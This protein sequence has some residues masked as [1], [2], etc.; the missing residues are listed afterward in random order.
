[1]AYDAGAIESTLTIDRDP[2]QAGLK[3]ARAEAK[4][5]EQQRF[6]AR[7]GADTRD[8][9]TA[10]K[11]LRAEGQKWDR[12]SYSAK[13]K[14][15]TRDADQGMAKLQAAARQFERTAPTIRPRADTASARAAL[16][17]LDRTRMSPKELRVTAQIETAL[18]NIDRVE[19][20][21]DALIRKRTDPKITAD[22]TDAENKVRSMERHLT[23][24]RSQTVTPQVEVQIGNSEAMLA[25]LQAHLDGLRDGRAAVDLDIGSAQAKLAMLHAQMAGITDTHATVDIDTSRASQRIA[26]LIMLIGTLGAA[27]STAGIAGA[28]GLAALGAGAMAVVPGI[29]AAALGFSGVTD[30]VKAMSDQQGKAAQTGAAAASSAKANANAQANAAAQ[31]ASAERSLANARASAAESGARAARAVEKAREEASEG[32]QRAIERERAAERTLAA[33]VRDRARVAEQTSESVATAIR[34]EKRA[35]DDLNESYKTARE[36]IIDLQFETIGGALAERRAVLQVQKAQEDLDA[37][38]RAGLRGRDMEEVAIAAEEATLALERQRVANRRTGEE[39]AD[40]DRRGVAGSREVTAATERATEATSARQRAERD[41]ADRIAQADQRV[42]EARQAAGAAAAAVDK[43]RRD[44]ISRVRDALIAEQS[45]QR[46]NQAAIENALAGV[47]SAHRAAQQAAERSGAAGASAADKA[48]EALDK[49]S[50][51]GQ[52]FA[53]YLLGLEGTWNRFRSTAQQEFLPGL[54]TGIERLLSREDDINTFIAR[55]SAAMGTLAADTGAALQSAE[56]VEFF[57]WLG[58]QAAPSMEMFGDITGNSLG[59]MA[60]LLRAAYP[61]WMEMGGAIERGTDIFHQWARAAERGDSPGFNRFLDNVRTYGPVVWET[62]VD[63]TTGAWHLI[64]SLAPMGGVILEVVG[65]FSQLIANTPGPVL[66]TLTSLLIA[67]AAAWKTF[68]A[69]ASIATGWTAITTGLSNMGIAM[70]KTNRS[71]DTGATKTRSLGGVVGRVAG[72]LPLLGLAVTGLAIAYDTLSTSSSEAADALLQ[73]G[74]AAAE[75]RAELAQNTEKHRDY[76]AQHGETMGAIREWTI[77]MLGTE[78]TTEQ[79]NAEL[80][81]R[82]DLMPPLEAAQ[83]RATLAQGNYEDAVREF[84]PTSQQAADASMAFKT[85]TREVEIQSIAT[86]EKIDEA[87]AAMIYQRD[88]NLASL[89]AN[90]RKRQADRD[91]ADAQKELADA[92]RDNGAGSDEAVA[93]QDRLEE[94][95]LRAAEAAKAGSGGQAAYN[96]TVKKFVDENAGPMSETLIGL[97]QNMDAAGWASIGARVELDNTGA[98]VLRLPD[99]KTIQLNTE[100]GPALEGISGL[101]FALQTVPEGKTIHL[102]AM[103]EPEKAKLQDLGFTVVTLP[104]GTV[105]VT[106]N[107]AQARGTLLAFQMFADWQVANPDLAADPAKAYDA[108]RGFLGDA[109]RQTGVPMLDADP[110]KADTTTRRK[111]DEFNRWEA[112]PDLNVDT[113]PADNAAKGWWGNLKQ[114][115]VDHKFTWDGLFGG[116]SGGPVPPPGAWRGGLIGY[117]AG[118]ALPDYLPHLAG[119]G[120]PGGL[121]VG[122]GTGTS[123]SIMA[124]DPATGTPTALVSNGEYVIRKRAVDALGVPTLDRLNA[125]A[126]GGPVLAR[127]AAGGGISAAGQATGAATPSAATSGAGVAV[128]PAAAEDAAGATGQLA[129]AMDIATAAAT[130]LDPTLQTLAATQSGLLAPAQN[131]V[132]SGQQ[133]LVAAG[134][135]PLQ[136]ALTGVLAP[137]LLGYQQQ[138]GVAAPAANTALQGAQA[139]TQASTTATAVNTQVNQAAM[140]AATTGSAITQQQQMSAVRVSQG[141]SVL[142]NNTLAGNTGYTTGQMSAATGTM[143]AMV[144][145]RLADVR[146]AQGQTNQATGYMA[147]WWRGQMGRLPKDAGDP[148]RWILINPIN[149]GILSAWRHLDGQFALNKPVGDV[150]IRFATGGRVPGAG[151]G[152]TVPAMLTPGEFVISKPVVE[153]WGIS[154]IAAA[155]QAAAKPGQFPG[156]EGMFSGENTRAGFAEVQGFATGGPVL[157]EQGRRVQYRATGGAIDNAVRVGQSMNGKRYVWGGNGPGGTDC[158]GFVAYITR[159]LNM[160]PNPYQRIGTTASFPWGGFTPGRGDWTVGNNPGS[161]MA[162]TLNVGGRGINIESGGAHNTSAFGGPAVGSDDPQFPQHFF[163]PQVGGQFVSGGGG[164]AAFDPT[165]LVDEAFAHTYRMIG[166]ITRFFPNS[167]ANQRTQGMTRQGAD[168]VKG[169][170]LEK[171]Q[172]MFMSGGGVADTA[173]A[174]LIIGIGKGMGFPRKG[175]EVALVTAFQES[176]LRNINYGDRDSL[177]IFQQRPSMGWGTP[178][179]I[180]N[181]RYS[182]MKFYEGLRGVPGW[183]GMPHTVAAQRVQRSAFPDAYAKWVGQAVNLVNAS[184]IYDNGGPLAPDSMAIN[185]SRG[186]EQV[187][188][189]DQREA[190]TRRLDRDDAHRITG[191]DGGE[192]L[193]ELQQLRVELVEVITRARSIHVHPRERQSEESIAA[194]VQ[195]REDRDQR[196]AVL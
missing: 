192:L 65:A 143:A 13:V 140:A 177:G 130:V 154:N 48:R 43:A 161:H 98:A 108:M 183:E 150:P 1:M 26:T 122:P 175:A 115:F 118:G 9:D 11:K 103:T 191:G 194:M 78:T 21:L 169:K 100:N 141:Q 39:K 166:D 41:A 71:T 81:K 6:N 153:R 189:S 34:T 151:A 5:F 51:A 2:F 86:R 165:P 163:L 63:L 60:Q 17:Q 62:I 144:G 28:G 14:A 188:T 30:A 102:N 181:P 142:A 24:L 37:A 27:A 58:Q 139:A 138:I 52:R 95:Q 160:D 134:V 157:D 149:A 49:L 135:L 38:R 67:G 12:T 195:R 170:A 15:D 168:L 156:L 111:L 126:A 117:A 158:S 61:L 44:G 83:A 84:G 82:I 70:D 193:V 69:A 8:A 80:Q 152:D 31:V 159:A 105:N 35:R 74:T 131:L 16:E 174:N 92:I 94:S 79:A 190:L 66:I 137:A 112:K 93:A 85:A 104:D 178:A 179:Q 106:A 75:M 33:A 53:R 36:R 146:V 19:A 56:W 121:L 18:A 109:G 54:Q 50:P 187:L 148:I 145:A 113:K 123:D 40:S 23:A 125:L 172:A 133:N 124:R 184:G 99:G 129:A 55:Y 116:S 91:A 42:I 164:G 68:K 89:D 90:L 155:H 22:I 136:A 110:A 96:D 4:Q 87:T 167:A 132:T 127:Y 97:V 76:V 77:G 119:G 196:A 147:D 25:R 107:D 185:L 59:G 120:G 45:Q 101:A 46:Q 88:Q 186:T 162:G 32:V 171:L 73:G 47:Q 3:A 29:G 10:L 7:L 176:G 182:T 72:G 20:Q 57:D 173:L 180:M 64:E 128:D 114:W